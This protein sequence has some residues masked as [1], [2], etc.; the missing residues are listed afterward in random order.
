M[1]EMNR[2]ILLVEDEEGDIEL[3]TNAMKKINLIN[4]IDVARDGEQALNYL[5][6][7]AEYAQRQS[8]DPVLVL[9]DLKMP[10]VDGIEVL[11]AMKS[12]SAL[13]NIPVVVVTS[14][15]EN[16]DIRKCYELGVNAYV[17]KPVDFKEFT[18]AI[19][20]I[21]LFWL[22]INQLPQLK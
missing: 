11:K 13:R 9:L 8:D 1:N 22:L 2:N 4:V 12:D 18:E 17:V 20:S 19:K 15:R 6:R 7:R 16:P 14:S 10:K 5:Y 3:I 21:G